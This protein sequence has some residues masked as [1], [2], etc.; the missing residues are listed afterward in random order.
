MKTI[1]SLIPEN[2]LRNISRLRRLE[3]LIRAALPDAAANRVR[4]L[5]LEGDVCTLSSPDNNWASNLR[6]YEPQIRS[7][8]AEKTGIKNVRLKVVN[9]KRQPEKPEGTEADQP[10]KRSSDSVN[11]D[12]QRLRNSVK[13]W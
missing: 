6:F 4:L 7:V 5:K 8:I 13:D 3:A 9:E 10:A 12:R 2:V 1:N 11:L